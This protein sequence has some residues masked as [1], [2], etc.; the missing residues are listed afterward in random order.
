[1]LVGG[2]GYSLMCGH[3]KTSGMDSCEERGHIFRVI[4]FQERGIVLKG[5]EDISLNL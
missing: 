4:R 1:M 2:R 5:E 3:G